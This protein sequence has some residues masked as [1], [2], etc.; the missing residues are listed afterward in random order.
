[1]LRIAGNVRGFERIIPHR[2][3]IKGISDK[4]P[5]HVHLVRSS[6]GLAQPE[7]ILERRP[8]SSGAP[9]VVQQREGST[10]ICR[11]VRRVVLCCASDDTI[12]ADVII[13]RTP[14]ST[15]AYGQIQLAG[16]PSTI[17]VGSRLCIVLY[18]S[19][20]V[21]VSCTVCLVVFATDSGW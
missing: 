18:G 2:Q 20:T 4:E 21:Y 8:S 5:Q 16:A 9:F 12:V 10:D 14:M 13:A 6:W 7:R 1:M 11:A 15:S 3:L 19:C 17:P